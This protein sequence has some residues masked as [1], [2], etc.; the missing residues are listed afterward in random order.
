MQGAA[1]AIGDT[2]YYGFG[3]VLDSGLII[4]N[5]FKKFFIGD[6][7]NNYAGIETIEE[8]TDVIIF[9]NPFHDMCNIELSP[10]CSE[11]P[12]F[13]LLNVEGEQVNVNISGSNSNYELYKGHLPAGVYILS[14]TMNGITSYKKLSILN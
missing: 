14:I 11:K 9:P 1:F 13:R 6:S 8:K 10:T 3:C 4:R 7:C 12:I 2:G 5:V